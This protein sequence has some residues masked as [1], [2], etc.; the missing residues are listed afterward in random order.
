[1]NITGILVIQN[2]RYVGDIKG[3]KSWVMTSHEEVS[4]EFK[5]SV[6]IGLTN[7]G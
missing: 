2:L 5:N 7:L 3:V 4:I 6:T 1:L